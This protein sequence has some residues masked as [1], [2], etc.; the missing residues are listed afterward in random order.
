MPRIMRSPIEREA[1]NAHAAAQAVGRER[2]IQDL[3]FHG[4]AHLLRLVDEVLDHCEV[5]V[6]T[7]SNLG[8]TA[9]YVARRRPALPVFSCD[10]GPE[11]FAIAS[12]RAANL[13]NADIR[14]RPS[15][16]FLNDL[17]REDPAIARRVTLFYL[18]AHGYGFHWPLWDEAALATRRWRSAFMLVDD[19]KVEGR[20]EFAF[21]VRGD[22]ECS[23]ASIA[24]ELAP[25]RT[26]QVLQP[27]YTDRTSAFHPL[28]GTALIWWGVDFEPSAETAAR[29]TRSEIRR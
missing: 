20:P 2:N 6:E 9:V 1:V 15:P 27:S 29:F 24:P 12:E 4:D 18:D 11:A 26:Y 28:V 21:D 16:E 17:L 3:G 19:C 13:P 8:N 14:K 23:L 5:F 22:L 25:G 10:P 7:G